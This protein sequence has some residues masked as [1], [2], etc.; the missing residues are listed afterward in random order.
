MSVQI[1][2]RWRTHE[3]VVT[4]KGQFICADLNCDKEKGLKS[5]EVN[6]SY[7]EN[8]EKKNALVK[9]RK[10]IFHVYTNIDA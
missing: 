6:F 9:I 5:W 1:A 8:K 3:E 10:L 4:G 7:I 2:M